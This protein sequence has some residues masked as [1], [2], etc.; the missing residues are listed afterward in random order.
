MPGMSLSLG[1]F[2]AWDGRQHQMR[3]GPSG[4]WELVYSR[5]GC[6]GE[7]YK[8][9]VKNYEGHIYEKSD[10]YGFQQEVRPKTASIVTDLKAPTAWSDE[11]MDG[12][13]PQFRCFSPTH[14]YLRSPS[15]FLDACVLR[16][17]CPSSAEGHPLPPVI[18]S[19]L[20]PGARF[21]TYPRVSRS[22]DSLC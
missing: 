20:K 19:E 17:A 22:I 3:K 13:A 6:I 21:L 1:D 7:H 16:R 9:E 4:I 5:I 8:Y 10:P 15:G 18:V 12:A 2:N 14:F 11:S